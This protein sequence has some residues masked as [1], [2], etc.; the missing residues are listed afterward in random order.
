MERSNCAF[1]CW[2][3]GRG[4]L[5]K[6]IGAK[7]DDRDRQFWLCRRSRPGSI[8]KM[9][10][11]ASGPLRIA[12]LR[13]PS[14]WS[15]RNRAASG[16]VKRTP[17]VQPVANMTLISK[18][19]RAVKSANAQCSPRPECR[20]G[21]PACQSIPP[22]PPSGAPVTTGSWSAAAE[23]HWLRLRPT[24]RAGE[25][26]PGAEQLRP[27]HWPTAPPT[28]QPRRGQRCQQGYRS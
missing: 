20:E 1:D 16:M 28:S 25:K 4:Y 6:T 15:R 18:P 17:K 13:L 7:L 22:S 12:A 21:C 8:A 5:G 26:P 11:A 24:G 19:Y 3:S 2:C 9:V 23:D 27:G 10:R 14:P